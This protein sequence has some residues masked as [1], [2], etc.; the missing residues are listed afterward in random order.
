[1]LPVKYHYVKSN[2]FSTTS[3]IVI[4][5][6]HFIRI[7]GVVL[8][9]YNFKRCQ[10]I[11]QSLIIIRTGRWLFHIGSVDHV[12][13]ETVW[14]GNFR[15]LNESLLHFL[16]CFFLRWHSCNAFKSI[17]ESCTEPSVEHTWS[18]HPHP[19]YSSIWNGQS[20]F[21]KP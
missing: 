9:V 13:Y 16:Q 11:N 2:Y 10:L 7:D 18:P 21:S 17:S 1:M 15:L 3:I 6:K 12:I 20:I 19:K 4:V 14:N 5:T 8:P